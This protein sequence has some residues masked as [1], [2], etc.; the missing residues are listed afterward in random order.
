MLQYPSY[1]HSNK[2]QHQEIDSMLRLPPSNKHHIQHSVA[3][4]FTTHV[5]AFKPDEKSRDFGSVTNVTTLLVLHRVS[6]SF[7]L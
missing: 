1:H 2:E 6:T 5:W 7:V 3:P 4:G